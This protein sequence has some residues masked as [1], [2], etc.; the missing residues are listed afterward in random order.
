MRSSQQKS[1][2][3]I[4]GTSA[5]HAKKHPRQVLYNIKHPSCGSRARA[6]HWCCW[7]CCCC[8]LTL[9]CLRLN[10]DGDT[11][12][13]THTMRTEFP[14][15]RDMVKKSRIYKNNNN[16]NSLVR[17]YNPSNDINTIFDSI[18]STLFLFSTLVVFIR[19]EFIVLKMNDDYD[20]FI[21]FFFF[22][23][24]DALQCFSK[25]LEI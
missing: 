8:T 17:V 3:Y 22:C 16:N 21:F 2:I 24:R 1:F 18:T 20:V 11:H 4:P 5:C 25:C 10:D 23:I 7:C 15:T 12:T 14:L 6:L 13:H 19:V 9:F